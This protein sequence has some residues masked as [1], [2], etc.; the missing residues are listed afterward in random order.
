[1]LAADERLLKQV[2]VNLLSN[3]VKFTPE[4][5]P[6]AWRSPSIPSGP[7][8]LLTV[9]DTGIG[10]PTEGVGRLFQPFVQLDSSLTRQYAGT[11]LGLALVKRMVELHGGS[12]AGAEQAGKGSRFTVSLPWHDPRAEG[13]GVADVP[14]A[15]RAPFPALRRS[16]LV[17]DDPADDEPLLHLLSQAGGR[18]P[19]PLLG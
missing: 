5:E 8:A 3:A 16:L 1:M 6:S 7:F 4:G 12:V 14:A 19:Y 11:G 13:N 15:N 10:I 17:T 9:W 18:N 2:L